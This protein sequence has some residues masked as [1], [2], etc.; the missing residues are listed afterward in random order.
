MKTEIGIAT[1]NL[2]ISCDE[3]LLGAGPR[4]NCDQA[5][6]VHAA[7]EGDRSAATLAIAAGCHRPAW[8]ALSLRKGLYETLPQKQNA[9]CTGVGDVTLRCAYV[10]RASEHNARILGCD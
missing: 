2:A 7:E 3:L 5:T 6:G 10:G 8:A 9:G 1:N 4:S